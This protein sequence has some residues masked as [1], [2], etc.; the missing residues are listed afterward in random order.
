MMLARFFSPKR[1][2]RVCLNL[3]IRKRE[4]PLILGV[5][6]NHHATCFERVFMAYIYR[7]PVK[8]EIGNNGI[9]VLVDEINNAVKGYRSR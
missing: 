7:S 3:F 9:V 4:I 8:I 2:D 1:V 6:H 5:T